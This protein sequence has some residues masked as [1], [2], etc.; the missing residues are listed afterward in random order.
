M[1]TWAT[2]ERKPEGNGN[3]FTSEEFRGILKVF[4]ETNLIF[5][6]VYTESCLD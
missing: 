6:A 5:I 2:R 1:F 4:S 3:R